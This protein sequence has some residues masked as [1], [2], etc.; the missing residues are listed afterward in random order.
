MLGD[1]QSIDSIKYQ[2]YIDK[3][4]S[5][6]VSYH[7]MHNSFYNKLVGNTNVN[8]WNSIPVMTKKDLQQ[9][10]EK[11]LSKGFNTKNTYVNKT[12]GSSGDPFIF[13]KDKFSHALTWAVIQN[14]FS[15]YDISFN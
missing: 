15:W 4:K 2:E 1:I 12:S 14:R 7:I 9:P 10:L 11:R 3:K 13:A 5:E 6:I 8:H